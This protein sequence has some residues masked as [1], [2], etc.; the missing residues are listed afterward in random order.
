P[1]SQGS[2]RRNPKRDRIC[3]HE[4]IEALESVLQIINSVLNFHHNRVRRHSS[5]HRTNRRSKR[6]HR[7]RI[8]NQPPN[9]APKGLTDTLPK[10]LNSR[11]NL[12][13]PVIKTLEKVPKIRVHF[14]NKFFT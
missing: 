12:L 8:L 3:R 14:R 11:G 13:H 10:I 4:R 6:L 1:N 7:T 2:K 9:N 5:E